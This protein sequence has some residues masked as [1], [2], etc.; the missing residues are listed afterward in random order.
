MKIDNRKNDIDDLLEKC[1]SWSVE[2]DKEREVNLKRLEE[3]PT[4]RIAK[5][6]VARCDKDI[7]ELSKLANLLNTSGLIDKIED[8]EQDD[9]PQ[10]WYDFLVKLGYC[11]SSE[12]KTEKHN[13]LNLKRIVDR[14]YLKDV[15]SFCQAGKALL[16]C[17][18]RSKNKNERVIMSRK[19]WSKNL[20]TLAK[21]ENKHFSDF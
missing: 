5:A 20:K 18:K 15:H 12:D 8:D 9:D 6:I 14:C 10:C 19:L 7:I 21:Q 3:S 17:V 16:I 1:L 13:P 2:I 11:I 4:N